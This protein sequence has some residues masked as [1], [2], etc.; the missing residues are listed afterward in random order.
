MSDYTITNVAAQTVVS[1][2]QTSTLTDFKELFPIW[3]PKV[4]QYAMSI[5]A[6]IVGA[7]FARYHQ[8]DSEV[9]IIELGLPISGNVIGN[10]DFAQHEI[11]AT[12]VLVIEHIGPYDNLNKAWSALANALKEQNL[13]YNGPCWESYI[14]DPDTEPDPNK[15]VTK[16]YQPIK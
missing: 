16:L 9:V 15:W 11:P 1:T 2:I 8:F 4:Y 14:T 10:G 6:T 3:L 5:G 12:K 13:E 7:P